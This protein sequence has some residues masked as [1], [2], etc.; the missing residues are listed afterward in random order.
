MKDRTLQYENLLK[1]VQSV[2]QSE[3]HHL[4]NMANLCVLIKEALGFHWVGFYLVDSA[5]NQLYLGPYQGPLACTE[6]PFGKGVCGGAWQSKE[7]LVVDDVDQF[8]GHIA[9]SSLSR[10]EIVYPIF[11]KKDVFAVLDIDSSELSDFSEIDK[12]FLGEI[13]SHLESCFK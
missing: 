7:V 10:S 1:E 8:P 9:C 6:I 13:V 2:I 3:N 4:S 12:H 11:Y 5:L